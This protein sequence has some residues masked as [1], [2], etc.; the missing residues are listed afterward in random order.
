MEE[1]YITDIENK[2]R[3]KISENKTKLQAWKEVTRNRKKD[4]G[5]YQNIGK[6]FNGAEIVNPCTSHWLTVYCCTPSNHYISDY[7]YADNMTIDDIFNSISER[8]SDL[9]KTIQDQESDLENC[10]EIITYACNKIESVLDD[11]AGHAKSEYLLDRTTELISS[12]YKYY[13]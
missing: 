8:I 9:E 12:H 11:L 13:K 2:L 7:I 5:D 1:Y 10:R 3:E 4:G 6:N